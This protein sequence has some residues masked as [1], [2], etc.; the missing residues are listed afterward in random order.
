[1]RPGGVV[2]MEGGRVKDVS[3]SAPTAQTMR[4]LGEGLL[5]PGLV[6]AHTHLELSFLAG[7]TRPRGDFVSWLEE[8][9]ALRPAHDREDAHGASQKAAAQM[10]RSGTACVADITNTG[11]ARDV[12]AQAGLSAVSFFEALGPVRCEPPDE[13]ISWQGPRL[14]ATGIAAHSPYSVPGLRL[15]ALKRRAGRLPFCLH[16]A[17]SRAEMEFFADQGK[18]GARFAEFL[19]MRGVKRKALGLMAA[20]P[21]AHLL[22]LGVVDKGTLLVHGVQLNLDEVRTLAQ[23]KAS[24]CVC[25][26]SNLALTG[27]VAPVEELLKAGV[28][29]AMGTDSLASAPDLV[30]WREMA[31]LKSALPALD[32]E[33]ILAMATTGGAEA[34]GLSAH[35]GRIKPGA[36]G[37]LAFVP[38]PELSKNE[39]LDAVVSGAFAAA[40][41]SVD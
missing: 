15:A 36:A 23:T 11:Q 8:L 41:F 9:V 28:N 18:D 14:S 22:A 33:G 4:D 16:L 37:P 10:A 7:K 1:M 5:L 26:R 38:L 19:R 3:G 2:A 17:E 30:L 39:V 25:P 24:L 12:L 21:L 13:K 27:S 29:L 40:P 32:P 34:L 35:F 20:R 6:N 31:A